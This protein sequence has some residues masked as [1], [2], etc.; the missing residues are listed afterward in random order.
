MALKID[1]EKA[2]DFMN[3]DYIKACLFAFG[4]NTDWYL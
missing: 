4:F 3:W 2:Y 1:L